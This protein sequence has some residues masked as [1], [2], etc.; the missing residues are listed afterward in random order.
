MDEVLDIY[1]RQVHH[2]GSDGVPIEMLDASALLWRLRLAGIDTGD[3]FTTLATAWE[4]IAEADP[5]YVFNDAHAAMAFCGADRLGDARR[6]VS[7]LERSLEQP[8]AD[9]TN[10]LMTE[11]VGLAVTRA[12][13][14]HTEVVTTTWPRS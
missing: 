12:L 10:R 7:R 13:L 11:M 9:G 4:R 3:R 2:A 8:A 14:A 6:L 5:W 1:D